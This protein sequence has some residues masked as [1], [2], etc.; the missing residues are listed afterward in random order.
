M[1]NRRLTIQIISEGYANY[2]LQ[3]RLECDSMVRSNPRH[4][5]SWPN[6][7][8]IFL[9]PQLEMLT[10]NIQ[11]RIISFGIDLSRIDTDDILSPARPKEDRT[12]KEWEGAFEHNREQIRA[13][14]PV[15]YQTTIL[16]RYLQ[17]TPRIGLLDGLVSLDSERRPHP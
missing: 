9:N 5:F 13:T 8:C 15:R 16:N 14:N 7:V 3:P 4:C 12:I 6:G 17:I 2:P 10:M 11:K 1:Q